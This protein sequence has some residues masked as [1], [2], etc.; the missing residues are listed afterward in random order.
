MKLLKLRA[1]L[2]EALGLRKVK[3]R[4]WLAAVKKLP[5]SASSSDWTASRRLTSAM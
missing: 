5:I 1:T 4:D 2:L 3:S